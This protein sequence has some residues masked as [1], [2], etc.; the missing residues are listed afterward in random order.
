MMVEVIASSCAQSLNSNDTDSR[1]KIPVIKAS[2]D[3]NNNQRMDNFRV[4]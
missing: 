4:K 1:K 3:K 2:L